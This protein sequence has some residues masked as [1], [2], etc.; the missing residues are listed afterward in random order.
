M[1]KGRSFENALADEEEY[2]L[3][4]LKQL[5]KDYQRDV[6]S[7]LRKCNPSNAEKMRKKKAVVDAEIERRL[8]NGN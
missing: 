3:P 8:S 2:S 7:W 1:S 4:R 6:D 5:S